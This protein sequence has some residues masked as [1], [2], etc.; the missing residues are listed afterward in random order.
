MS[1]NSWYNF[2]YGKCVIVPFWYTLNAYQARLGILDQLRLAKLLTQSRIK[3]RMSTVHIFRARNVN[4]I[5]VQSW[6]VVVPCRVSVLQTE[7]A[8]KHLKPN[9]LCQKGY[10]IV[11]PEK[12]NAAL[13]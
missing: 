5:F 7:H 10:S 6:H 13:Y 11:A 8:S 3:T 12:Q 9:K 1:P 4:C 2:G